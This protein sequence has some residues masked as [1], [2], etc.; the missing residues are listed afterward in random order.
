MHWAR[1][2]EIT[3]R[4]RQ[5]GA[6]A[7]LNARGWFEGRVVVSLIWEVT[8][9][10][11]RDVGAASPTL[12]AW[13][14]G[15]VDGGLLMRDSHDVVAEERLRIEVGTRKGVR[16]E[17]ATWLPN[18]EP[19]SEMLYPPPRLIE[20]GVFTSREAYL[21]WRAP[22]K[23]LGG[24]TPCDMYWTNDRD[25]MARVADEVSRLLEGNG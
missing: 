20:A 17:I 12:K 18:E 6:Y 21:W 19:M 4:I 13:I 11:R 9:K 25:D 5:E 14:D 23:N 7:A 3:R 15:L 10:R 24:R 16:V 1:K 8:D 2:A 22:N